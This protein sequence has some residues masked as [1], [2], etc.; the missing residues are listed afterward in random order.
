[1]SGKHGRVRPGR[2]PFPGTAARPR[3]R[4]APARP[5]GAAG[6]GSPPRAAAAGSR[7]IFRKEALEFHARG[8]DLA[9]GVVRL[10]SPWLA[11]C[12]R[13]TFVLVAAGVAG[14]MLA[15]T[16]QSSYGPAV[17]DSRSGRFAALFPAAVAADLAT[18]RGLSFVLPG[19]GL[20]P[21]QVAAVH[22]RLADGKA[23]TRAGLATPG[24]PSILLTG[25]L[26]AA[27]PP[28]AAPLRTDAV[29]VLPTRSLA[30]VLGH[31]LKVMLGQ[32]GAGP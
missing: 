14:V 6:P 22:V 30:A 12:Y 13:L 23:V 9:G 25:R 26:L 11:W 19:A 8:R 18:A 20:Q 21:V 31:E 16:G 5:A 4:S 15:Q 3:R 17:I 1:M 7:A 32:G 28:A 10:G 2:G 29:V 24:Q 27:I